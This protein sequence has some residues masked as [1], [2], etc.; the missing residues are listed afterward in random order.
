MLAAVPTNE[1][2][3]LE[4]FGL[5]L[6]L[7]SDRGSVSPQL[8]EHFDTVLRQAKDLAKDPSQVQGQISPQ[9]VQLARRLR[10]VSALRDAVDPISDIGSVTPAVASRILS[11]LGE[12]IA[13]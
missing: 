7:V 4:L 1:L 3:V 8:A 6:R 5:A 2:R 13:P 12:S 10:E 9:A 11:S